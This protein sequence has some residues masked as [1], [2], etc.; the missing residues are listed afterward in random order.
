[1]PAD[2]KRIEEME[3]YLNECTEA[4]RGLG[5]QLDNMDAV[6]DKMISLF[7]YYGSEAWYED[8]GE[9]DGFDAGESAE[10]GD[11]GTDPGGSAESGAAD[12]LPPCGVLSE[13]AVY[14]LITDV[15]DAAFDMMELAA[16]ILKNRI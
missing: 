14:D 13:D 10:S 4:V 9:E 1:M 12:A 7:Q 16:D 3:K 2:V 15:R 6:R 8:R 11:S 5:E